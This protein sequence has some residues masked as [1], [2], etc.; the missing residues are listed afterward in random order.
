[1]ATYTRDQ[2]TAYA[3]K[4]GLVAVP[5][6]EY[7]QLVAAADAGTAAEAQAERDYATLFGQNGAR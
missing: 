3:A 7:Q 5:K 4:H 2:I 1:M 6:A